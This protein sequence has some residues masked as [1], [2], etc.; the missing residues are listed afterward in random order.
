MASWAEAQKVGRN[1]SV[2][3]VDGAVLRLLCAVHHPVLGIAPEVGDEALE[4]LSQIPARRHSILQG[5]VFEVR[6]AEL[7]QTP[8]GVVKI[9]FRNPNGRKCEKCGCRCPC[10]CVACRPFCCSRKV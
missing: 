3:R 2:N 1:A 5:A 9:T 8:T 4:R 7:V 10:S 6:G